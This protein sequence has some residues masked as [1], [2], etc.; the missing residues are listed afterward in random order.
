MSRLNDQNVALAREI[1]A[2]YPRNAF[3][4]TPCRAMTTSSCSIPRPHAVEAAL[5]MLL[6]QLRLAR[7]RSHW[8]SLAS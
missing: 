1:I 5:P 3:L 8:Q 4:N 6:K 2:R 7:F